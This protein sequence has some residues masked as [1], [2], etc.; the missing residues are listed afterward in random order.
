MTTQ[1]EADSTGSHAW[2]RRG[3]E[4][5][6]PCLSFFRLTALLISSIREEGAKFSLKQYAYVPFNSLPKLGTEHHEL[7][8]HPH[9]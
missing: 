3:K 8:P 6:L 7:K 9:G 1:Q 4:P 2:S 5:A